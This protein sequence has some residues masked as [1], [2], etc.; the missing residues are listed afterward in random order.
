MIRVR[1]RLSSVSLLA[2]PLASPAQ[3]PANVWLGCIEGKNVTHMGSWSNARFERFDE[4]EH[5]EGAR[6]RDIAGTAAARG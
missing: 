6:A 5:C 4:P 3:N 1:S 2:A